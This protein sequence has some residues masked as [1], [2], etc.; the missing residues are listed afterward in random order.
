MNRLGWRVRLGDQ[1]CEDGADS[2]EC[3]HHALRFDKRVIELQLHR[4]DLAINE[5]SDRRV[6]SSQAWRLQEQ[7]FASRSACFASKGVVWECCI[8]TPGLRSAKT[9]QVLDS[10]CKWRIWPRKAHVLRQPARPTASFSHSRRKS[11]KIGCLLLH[12]ELDG[13]PPASAGREGEGQHPDTL[14]ST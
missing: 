1:I 12:H 10:L 13:A 7:P 2:S 3:L 9:L 5:N 8:E 4:P 11:S 6:H 14:T